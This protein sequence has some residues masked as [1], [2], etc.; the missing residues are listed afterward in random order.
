MAARAKRRAFRIPQASPMTQ[1]RFVLNFSSL[2]V[3]LKSSEREFSNRRG[4]LV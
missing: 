2:Q 1:I 4:E 3:L